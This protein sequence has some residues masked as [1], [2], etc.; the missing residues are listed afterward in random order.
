MPTYQNYPTGTGVTKSRNGSYGVAD[1]VPEQKSSSTTGY[2]KGKPLYRSSIMDGEGV[3]IS[4]AGHWAHHMPSIMN[5]DSTTADTFLVEKDDHFTR[6]PNMPVFEQ[7]PLSQERYDD[8][9]GRPT[10]ARGLGDPDSIGPSF[11]GSTTNVNPYND[12]IT[13]DIITNGLYDHEVKLNDGEMPR[14]SPLYPFYRTDP[15]LAQSTTFYY[16]NRTKIPVADLAWRKG[17]RHIFITRPECY[18]MANSDNGTLCLSEQCEYDE[19]FLTAYHQFPYILRILS[20]CYVTG[21]DDNFNYLLSNAALGLNATSTQ[22]SVDETVQK[23][24]DGY[25]VNPA[26][27]MTSNIGSTLDIQFR[28]TKTLDVYNCLRLWMDYEYKTYKGILAP[29]YNGYHY[30]NS[31]ALGN[32]KDDIKITNGGDHEDWLFKLHPYDRALDYC[33]SLFDIVTNESG[34]KI[35]YWCKY[36]GIYPI[37]ATPS[38]L[39]NT[40]NS[41]L[42]QEMTVNATFRYQRKMEMN[43]K[44][45][46]E[47]NY[48]S[49]VVNADGT[50]RTNVYSTQPWMYYEDIPSDDTTRPSKT[51]MG[52]AGMFTGAPYIVMTNDRSRVDNTAPNQ[53]RP[54]LYFKPMV[55]NHGGTKNRKYHEMNNNIESDIAS[56]FR[57]TSYANANDEFVPSNQQAGS[58]LSDNTDIASNDRSVDFNGLT[59]DERARKEAALKIASGSKVTQYRSDMMATVIR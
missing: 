43:E 3:E 46:V 7:E 15:D 34:T 55:M 20:P 47:F 28:E 37:Q 23:S 29:S 59:K 4:T 27:L 9:Q 49:G 42:T 38:G 26:R 48:N 53:F 18:I 25:S 31:Y 13:K 33:A 54:V 11:T 36:Y 56:T 8:S 14:I 44:T 16:Y 30:H 2:P 22:M 39:S 51:Y 6:D 57:P 52:A 19:E 10:H 12:V 35:L 58:N 1:N 17:F 32:G 24:I 50:L 45:F 41:P 21:S 5:P 40:N